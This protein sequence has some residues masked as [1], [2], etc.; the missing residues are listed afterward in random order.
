MNGK[1]STYSKL[2]SLLWDK[3]IAYCHS[4]MMISCTNICLYHGCFLALNHLCPTT[5][6][7]L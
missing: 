3:K 1:Q 7:R 5:V 6:K 4:L 2:T